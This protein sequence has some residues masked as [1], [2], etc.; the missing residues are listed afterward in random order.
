MINF[1][2]LHFNLMEPIFPELEIV[3][4]T[5]EEKKRKM[6]LVEVFFCVLSLLFSCSLNWFKDTKEIV[7]INL[8]KLS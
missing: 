1:S 3:K 8:K 7:L 2:G 4:T 6:K 5:R